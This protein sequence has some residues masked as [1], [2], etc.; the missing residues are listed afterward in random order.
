[1]KPP[2]LLLVAC[3]L[4]ASHVVSAAD[5]PP[6]TPATTPTASPAPRG[7]GAPRIDW[8]AKAAPWGPLRNAPAD[9][10]QKT[11]FKVF[12]NVYYVGLQTVAAYI[13]TTS[14]G[15][16]LLDAAYA[17]TTDQLLDNVRALGF[18]PKKIKYIIIS[19]A[20]GDHFAGAGAIAQTSGAKV[21][22]SALDWGVTEQTQARNPAANGIHLNRDIVAEDGGS[23]K[24]GDTA[25]KFYVTPGHTPGAL[26]VEFQAKDGARSY[27]SLSPGGLGFNFGPEWTEPYLKSYARLKELGPWETVLPN[28][29]YMG[30]R[31]LFEIEKDLG[32]RGNSPHPA[33]YGPEKINVWLDGI[34]KAASEKLAYEK[35]PQ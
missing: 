10:Q 4:A 31:D 20:H 12:D 28:H 1:M 9:K 35:K 16:V 32:K 8:N 30:P 27:R 34:V 29:A 15:L 2:H 22:M 17:Y 3:A 18:D 5:A 6:A 11:P 13:V 23:L 24:V 19:H 26:T 14:D 21:V 25:F 33:V 7:G